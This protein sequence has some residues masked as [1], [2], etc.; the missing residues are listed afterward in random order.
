VL[1]AG[2]IG[3]CVVLFLI[4]IIAPRLSGKVE[5]AGDAPL[6]GGQRVAGEAPGRLGRWFQKPFSTSRKAVHKSGST[7]RK[8]R[9]KLP[10]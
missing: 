5:R 9:F 4:A 3:F 7:G 8:T 2:I 10:F 6:R 1:I